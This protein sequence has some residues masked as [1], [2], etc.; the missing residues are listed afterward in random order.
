MFHVIKQKTGP[1]L[2][3]SFGLDQSNTSRIHPLY[4]F[5]AIQPASPSYNFAINAAASSKR[6]FE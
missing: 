2:S 6:V 5:R 3:K 1:L 4:H